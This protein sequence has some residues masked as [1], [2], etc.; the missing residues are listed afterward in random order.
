MNIASSSRTMLR[1]RAWN[2]MQYSSNTSNSLIRSSMSSWLLKISP[3]NICSRYA[4]A[5]TDKMLRTW[6][7][8]TGYWPPSNTLSLW[9]WCLNSKLLSKVAK[10]GSSL[11]KM[12]WSKLRLRDAKRSTLRN[13]LK[14]KV[15]I[16]QTSLLV[17]RLFWLLELTDTLAPKFAWHS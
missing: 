9:Q 3:L 15:K 17:S 12:S 16:L 11:S 13:W 4:N 7:V 8:L 14:R 2:A 6:Y 10:P 1:N 5:Y